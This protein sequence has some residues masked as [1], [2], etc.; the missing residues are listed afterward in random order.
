MDAGDVLAG[1]PPLPEV[2]DDRAAVD[3]DL[4]LPGRVASKQGVARHGRCHRPAPVGGASRRY[5]EV[6]RLGPRARRVEA[7]RLRKR[8]RR[9]DRR[10]ART[11][12]CPRGCRSRGST[13][14]TG[15]KISVL[16][17]RG[18]RS[19]SLDRAGPAGAG[20]GRTATR[21]RSGS[22]CCRTWRVDSPSTV[23]ASSV[24]PP[25][26]SAR[27]GWP[28][29]LRNETAPVARSTRTASLARRDRRLALP[30]VIFQG[31]DAQRRR[32]HQRRARRTRGPEH[33]RRARCP[34]REISILRCPS[35]MANAGG[36]SSVFEALPRRRR[37]SA[38]EKAKPP[39]APAHAVERIMAHSYSGPAP[40]V[41]S[42][43]C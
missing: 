40:P 17:C 18:S 37:T 27:M 31:V 7:G 16:T 5:G 38:C 32:R 42:R 29:E 33:K 13:P 43:P 24:L 3:T 12:C 41:E 11:R 25:A 19:W 20:R 39:P 22:H 8:H 23:A 1:Q 30:F 9:G 28:A 4:D 10:S 34:R 26:R 6:A 36:P 15:R 21:R 35:P 14:G 2:I